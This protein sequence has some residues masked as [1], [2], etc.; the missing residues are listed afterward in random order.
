MDWNRRRGYGDG[1]SFGEII[2]DATDDTI[3][4][5]DVLAQN[6]NVPL[7]VYASH[8]ERSSLAAERFDSAE[9]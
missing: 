3:S 4:V 7:D 2:Y 8:E 1:R 9:E 5:D 6:D